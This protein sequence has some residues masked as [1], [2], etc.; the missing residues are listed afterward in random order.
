MVGSEVLEVLDHG[1]LLP[2]AFLDVLTY[3]GPDNSVAGVAHAFK[4]MERAWPL[5]D[6]ARPPERYEVHIDSA[7]PG[8]GSRDAFEMVTRAVT[9]GRY[10]FVPE[11]APATAPEGPEGRFFFRIH[12]RAT[13][14]DLTLR[15]GFVS[16]RFVER[17]RRGA[18]TADEEKALARLK[19]AMAVRLMGLAAPQV[20]DA[21]VRE[22][23]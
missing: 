15:D 12:Y 22:E 1:T 6:A 10:R 21:T 20:Y 9:G 17:V 23:G 5:L 14:V 19:Q 8:D 3:H 7:F 2:V 18:Q 4:A 13:A 11:I 16:D